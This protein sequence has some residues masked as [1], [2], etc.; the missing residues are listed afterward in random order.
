M[1]GNDDVSLLDVLCMRILFLAS[2]SFSSFSDHLQNSSLSTLSRSRS[3]IS[4]SP[5]GRSRTPSSSSSSALGYLASS[6]SLN[7]N[8]CLD[9]PPLS[10]SS[11][12][13]RSYALSL[14]ETKS[15][16]DQHTVVEANL[17][18]PNHRA[19]KMVARSNYV[20]DLEY[21]YMNLSIYVSPFDHII[22]LL[23]LYFDSIDVDTESFKHRVSNSLASH[24]MNSRDFT[25]LSLTSGGMISPRK[26]ARKSPGSEEKNR[27]LHINTQVHASQLSSPSS[28]RDSAHAQIV[29]TVAPPGYS[30]MT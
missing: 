13:D 25:E 17:N 11:S 23:I 22:L 28:R 26:S 8:S 21:I 10:R 5:L 18:L 7:R 2:S 3:G 15:F 16:H 27:F 29:S 30:M 19:C 6:A 9:S 1:E 4:P 14:H 12:R 24:A 20:L